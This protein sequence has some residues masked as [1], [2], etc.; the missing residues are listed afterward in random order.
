MHIETGADGTLP[1]H[2]CGPPT[3]AGLAIRQ[4]AL[5]TRIA[6]QSYWALD[7]FPLHRPASPDPLGRFSD[8]LTSHN[9]F[10][11]LK[12]SQRAKGTFSRSKTVNNLGKSLLQTQF[13]T[14][15]RSGFHGTKVVNQDIL[16][17][18]RFL[19]GQRE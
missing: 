16:I 2:W 19:C 12:Q 14:E 11:D 3:V 1:L 6:E 15:G 18:R 7:G 17:S 10:R 9:R 5:P 8:G 13:V 4:S